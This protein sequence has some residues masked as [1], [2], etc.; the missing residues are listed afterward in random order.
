[1]GSVMNTNI[2]IIVW[3]LTLQ[4]VLVMNIHVQC[5]LKCMF[6]WPSGVNG[7]TENYIFSTLHLDLKMFVGLKIK[8]FCCA[9]V[10]FPNR[11]IM[12]P[13]FQTGYYYVGF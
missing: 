7:N 5:S 9:Y 8:D 6:L 13:F 3:I 12:C 4:K 2:Q 1:M 11:H 10:L